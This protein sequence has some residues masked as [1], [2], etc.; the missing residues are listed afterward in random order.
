MSERCYMT[1][2]DLRIF[3]FIVRGQDYGWDEK[4]EPKKRV[5]LTNP[6][7]LKDKGIQGYAKM[8]EGTGHTEWE[9]IMGSWMLDAV[10]E[11]LA[12]GKE[13]D[14]TRIFNTDFLA[15]TAD[16]GRSHFCRFTRENVYNHLI[17]LFTIMEDSEDVL[18][19]SINVTT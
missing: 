1:G 6:E 10:E 2:K 15:N 18:K 11:A 16:D 9:Y 13:C 7:V 12:S 3:N 4:P 8:L 5:I 14:I 19:I 17:S